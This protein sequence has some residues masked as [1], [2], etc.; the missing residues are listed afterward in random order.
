MTKTVA[1]TPVATVK[2]SDLHRWLTDV[3]PFASTDST[4]PQLNS[5]MIEGDANRLLAITT[6]RYA[7]G[8]SRLQA[9]K[10]HGNPFNDEGFVAQFALSDVSNLLKIAKTAARDADWRSVTL[11]QQYDGTMAFKFASGE[12]ITLRMMEP[13]F[14][15]W[16]HLIPDSWMVPG[17]TPAEIHSDKARASLAFTTAQLAKFAKVAQ[18]RSGAMVLFTHTSATDNGKV[19]SILI[20][21]DFMGLLMPYRQRD[22]WRTEWVKPDWI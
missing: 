18:D 22:G 1:G 6:N 21:D 12:T 5:V 10:V 11:V 20:G 9:D 14:P 13:D 8:V 2:T 7:L 16:R 4:V 17:M 19:Y 3:L 15:K